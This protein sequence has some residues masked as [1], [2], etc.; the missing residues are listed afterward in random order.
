MFAY[1]LFMN[2]SR[3]IAYTNEQLILK[4]P[5]MFFVAYKVISKYD[6]ETGCS[7]DQ[8]PPP[9]TTKNKDAAGAPSLIHRETIR[10]SL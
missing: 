7:T 10:G 6:D 2:V 5:Q 1:L 4:R 3:Q 9:P 8:S